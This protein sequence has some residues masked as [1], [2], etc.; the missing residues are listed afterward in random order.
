MT[1][2]VVFGLSGATPHRGNAF[3]AGD[4]VRD[5]GELSLIAGITR[6]VMRATRV[7]VAGLLEKAEHSTSVVGMVAADFHS[8]PNVASCPMAAPPTNWVLVQQASPNLRRLH[9]SQPPIPNTLAKRGRAPGSGTAGTLG[10]R[11]DCPGPE[12]VGPASP[13]TLAGWTTGVVRGRTRR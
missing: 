9:H 6:E 3:S 5:A 8:P 12:T 2:H 7:Y 1:L 4:R 13:G 10:P 11:T